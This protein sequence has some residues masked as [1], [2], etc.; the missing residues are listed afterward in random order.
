MHGP[1]ITRYQGKEATVCPDATATMTELETPI[2][3]ALSCYPTRG[4]SDVE[5]FFKFCDFARD[6]LYDPADTR[7]TTTA[8]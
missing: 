8:V 7:P 2:A 3:E 5:E 4:S 6:Q 1:I